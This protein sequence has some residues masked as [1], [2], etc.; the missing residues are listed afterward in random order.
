M[1]KFT[2]TGAALLLGTTAATAGGLDRS[3]QGIGALFEQ[4]QYAELSFGYVMPDVSGVLGVPSGD[5]AP[6]YLSLGG[7]YKQDINEQL[8]FAIIFDQP[9]GAAVDYTVEPTYPLPDV[10]ATLASTGFT[11]LG[12][13][14][15]NERFSVHGGLR[16]VTMSGQTDTVAV[17][18]LLLNFG[19]SSDVAYVAGAA[20]EIPAI[21]LRA[22][23]TYSSATTHGH[24]SDE[25]P[26]PGTPYFTI[27]EYTMPQSV[28]FDFQTGI[29]ADTLLL[30]SVR[31]VDWTETVLITPVGQIDYSNDSYTY[32]LGVGRKFSDSF[33]GVVR[34]TYEEDTGEPASNLSPTDGSL[35]VTLAGVYTMDNI[36]VTGGISFVNLGSAVTE[37][38][39]AVFQDNSAIG[40]GVKVGYS[41]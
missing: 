38:V 30:A 13:Y 40:I 24:E 14:K 18:G 20:Y 6:D 3:G 23:I 11:A 33:S 26:A 19:G 34:V 21:A 5:I 22:A 25:G 10:A 17:N 31:Y 8:S 35:A 1:I 39:N 9:Y 12:R 37:G 15:V 36:K 28:N 29:A 4:G 41:F 32:S 16:L 2:L 7:A 27:P